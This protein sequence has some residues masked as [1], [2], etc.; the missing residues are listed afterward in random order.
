VPAL[1]ALL[2]AG[3]SGGGGDADGA[4][5]GNV[6]P[7]AAG[8]GPGRDRSTGGA[9][10]GIDVSASQR[11]A[12]GLPALSP[13]R[14]ADDEQSGRVPGRGVQCAGQRQAE[15]LESALGSRRGTASAS[16]VVER[17]RAAG[18][19][20]HTTPRQSLPPAG[21]VIARI[22]HKPVHDLIPGREGD[23]MADG[24]EPDVARAEEREEALGLLFRH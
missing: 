24:T 13:G 3:A 23:A 20:L 12:D 10:G 16:G 15:V 21:R 17:R 11:G 5:P 18:P 2:L 7:S 19:L 8:G 22:N 1:A 9:G 14:P 4:L 6:G